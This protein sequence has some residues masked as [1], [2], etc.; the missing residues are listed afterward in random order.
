MVALVF[1]AVTDPEALQDTEKVRADSLE[2]ALLECSACCD[3]INNE[4][5]RANIN[6][7][8]HQAARDSAAAILL[9]QNIKK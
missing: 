3:H 2:K 9:T 7:L 5:T 6:Q 4:I 8:K 1:I